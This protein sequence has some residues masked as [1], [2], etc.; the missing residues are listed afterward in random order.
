MKKRTGG[1]GPRNRFMRFALILILVG[2][3]CHNLYSFIF[4]GRGQGHPDKL[5]YGGNLALEDGE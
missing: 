3:F 2:L 5:L 1:K 4:G